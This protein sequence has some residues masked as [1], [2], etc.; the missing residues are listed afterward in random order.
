MSATT[1]E[2][3]AHRRWLGQRPELVLGIL[4]FITVPAGWEFGV[5][6]LDVSMLVLPP[7]SSVAWALWQGIADNTLIW[8]TGVTLFETLGGFFIGSVVG[9]L[10]GALVGQFPLAER[11]LYPYIVAFQTVPKVAIAPLFVIWFGFG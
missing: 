7:P 5:R 2:L 11:T 6:A 3:E 10:L 4:L 9:L 1:D 8:H